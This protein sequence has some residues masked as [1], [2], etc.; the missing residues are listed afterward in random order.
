MGLQPSS[1][2]TTHAALVWRLMVSTPVNH[3]ITW[4]TTYL[5]TPMG[6]KAELACLKRS[7]VNQT[8]RTSGKVRQSKTDV[9]T[10]EP[11]RQPVSCG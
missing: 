2:T 9:L 4:I 8:R 1:Q 5:L 6:W 7:H 10:T 11:R 3:V